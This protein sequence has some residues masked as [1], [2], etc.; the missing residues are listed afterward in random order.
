[1]FRKMSVILILITFLAVTEGN[2]MAAVTFNITIATKHDL[3]S[4]QCRYIVAGVVDTVT[5]HKNYNIVLRNKDSFD[6]TL[7]TLKITR[8]NGA[9]QWDTTWTG[10]AGA[11]KVQAT[12]TDVTG[13]TRA[14]ADSV[15]TTS[16]LY[17]EPGLTQWGLIIL[18]ALIIVAG[19]YLWLRRKPVTA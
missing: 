9:T 7:D 1:M 5:V 3:G 12:L 16:L 19:V 10:I 17:F 4:N 13:F 11:V 2:I 18:I 8:T 6:V 15:Y 14:V